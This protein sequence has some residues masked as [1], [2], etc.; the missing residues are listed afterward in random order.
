M[1]TRTPPGP[2]LDPDKVAATQMLIE[3]G[4]SAGEAARQLGVGRA[5]AY[6]IAS[7]VRDRT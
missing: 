6:W 4:L 3:S 7:G 5:T 2:P 1:S